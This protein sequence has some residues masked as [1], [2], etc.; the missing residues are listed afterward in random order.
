MFKCGQNDTVPTVATVTAKTFS[1]N[2]FVTLHPSVPLSSTLTRA[3]GGPYDKKK[4]KK[5]QMT[6]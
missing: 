1:P 3:F 5:K 6:E 2:S 4:K